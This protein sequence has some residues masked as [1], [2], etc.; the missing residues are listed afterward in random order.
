MEIKEFIEE[1]NKNIP[2]ILDEDTY[3]NILNRGNNNLIRFDL[4]NK[5]ILNLLYKEN[6]YDVRTKEEWFSV[7]RKIINVEKYY[8]ILV[9]NSTIQYIDCKNNE[10][11]N[12]EQFTV[13]ELKKALELHIIEKQENI[14][15]LHLVKVYDI[16]N[17]TNID[18]EKEY[19]LT[20]PK[21]NIQNLFNALHK[22]TDITVEDGVDETFYSRKEKHLYLAKS[23][24]ANTISILSN[25]LVEY[26]MDSDVIKESIYNSNI[27]NNTE[28]EL[29]RISSVYSIN[30][31]FSVDS[32]ANL[33][34]KFRANRGINYSTLLDILK[35]TDQIIYIV[36]QM[37]EYSD[38]TCIT[39]ASTD[40]IKMKKSEIILDIMRANYIQLKLK[41]I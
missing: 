25:I 41:G 26:I 38:D 8:N 28:T 10:I 39:D 5:I 27:V 9:P 1:I 35:I 32:K 40:I 13:D 33:I 21:M 36:A 37:L 24:Y 23:N 29:I 4:L 31:L 14:E 11:V 34:E 18:K 15:D 20:K 30:S 7:G 19:K 3:V 16:R 12:I 6:I 2:K 22:F 17:T